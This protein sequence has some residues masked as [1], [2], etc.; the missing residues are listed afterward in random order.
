MTNPHLTSQREVNFTFHEGF[1]LL[2]PDAHLAFLEDVKLMAKKGIE[3]EKDELIS[4]DPWA[5]KAYEEIKDEFQD[6]VNDITDEMVFSDLEDKVTGLANIARVKVGTR[7]E[8][9]SLPVEQQNQHINA[10][11]RAGLKH[12]MLRAK[13]A[14]AAVIFALPER[15]A[16]AMK[17]AFSLLEKVI[18]R[19]RLAVMR[20]GQDFEPKAEPFVKHESEEQPPESKLVFSKPREIQIRFNGTH[21]FLS[22]DSYLGHFQAIAPLLRKKIYESKAQFEAHSGKSADIANEFVDFM[23]DAVVFGSL[24]EK[25]KVIASAIGIKISGAEA[26]EA[27]SIAEQS[28]MISDALI[29]GTELLLKL[30]REAVDDV[31]ADDKDDDIR[32]LIP[33]GF[34]LVERSLA[35]IKFSSTPIPNPNPNATQH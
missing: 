2:A 18:N 11:L 16:E 9:M 15:M 19:M 22:A 24:E 14:M 27:S 33:L 23:L 7:D 8:F 13:Q 5:K 3:H 30:S 1:L 29:A 34:I 32:P 28:K 35:R 31:T 6:V 4:H 21:G 20:P 12:L 25:C 17:L 10:V 26:Y